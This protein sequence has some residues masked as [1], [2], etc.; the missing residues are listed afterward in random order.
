MDSSRVEPTVF[1]VSAVPSWLQP[2][3]AF[4][5]DGG[6]VGQFYEP[7]LRQNFGVALVESASKGTPGESVPDIVGL[8][9]QARKGAATTQLNSA[10]LQYLSAQFEVLAVSDVAERSLNLGRFN[11]HAQSFVD[12]HHQ[13]Y[14]AGVLNVTG[15]QL[16]FVAMRKDEPVEQQ[17]F[18]R[19]LSSIK[20]IGELLAQ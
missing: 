5:I 12:N 4:G 11:V 2:V 9:S 18:E 14:I 15:R 17:G 19:F 10:V 6:A 20:P 1:F 16:A 8:V 7:N 3:H 13:H